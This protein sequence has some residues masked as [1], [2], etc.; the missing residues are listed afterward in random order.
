MTIAGAG[1]VGCYVGG[2]LALAGRDVTLLGRPDLM[3][4]ITVNGLRITDRDGR[5]ATLAPGRITTTTDPATALRDATLV[6][7]TVKSNATPVMAHLIAR[8][9][10]P[11]ET[12]V[13]LQNGTSNA[14]TLQ[15]ILGTTARVVPGMV[16]FNILQS[17]DAG[18]IPHMH[19]ATSGRIR[20]A[21]G[22]PSLVSTLDIPGMRTAAHRD[23]TAVA[24]GKLILN[25]NNALNALSGLTLQQQ[26]ADRR[27]RLILAAQADEALAAL[28]ATGIKPARIDRTSP[29]LM[30]FGLRLPNALFKL[31]SAAA[32]A[33]DPQARSSMWEDLDRRRPTEIA[34]LQGAII[35]LAAKAGTHAAMNARVHDLIRA[36]EAARQGA[37]GLTPEDVA[38]NIVKLD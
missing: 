35:D 7:V 17:R 22:M 38:G 24:W 3:H 23:M 14:A 2:C 28:H 9:T 13:S 19:R 31:A 4:A 27:W 29:N 12:V 11:G 8:H 18:D 26:L 15:R 6:L 16:P 21:A 33:I 1:S 34:H 32:P 10:A 37:P 30:P 20:V 5:D 36:A 25:L